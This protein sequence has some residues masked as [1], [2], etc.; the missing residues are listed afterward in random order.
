MSPRTPNLLVEW[1]PRWRAFTSALRPGLGRTP[2]LPASFTSGERLGAPRLLVL[3]EDGWR[4]FRE[5]LKPALAPSAEALETECDH[6]PLTLR[7]VALSLAVHALALMVAPVVVPWVLPPPGKLVLPEFSYPLTYYPPVEPPEQRAAVG[8]PIPEQEL[9]REMARRKRQR[10]RKPDET[11]PKNDEPKRVQ[12]A[13]QELQEQRLV[14]L[15]QSPDLPQME[16]A[17]GAQEGRSGRSG[18]REAFHPTQTIR[19]ARGPRMVE[20]VVDAPNLNLPRSDQAVANLVA[21]AAAPPPPPPVEA[22]SLGRRLLLPAELAAEVISPTAQNVGRKLASLPAAGG[23]AIVPPPPE[24]APAKAAVADPRLIVPEPTVVEPTA[25]NVGREARR[26]ALGS[27]GQIEAELT[28]GFEDGSLSGARTTGEADNGSPGGRPDGVRAAA[29][30]TGTDPN[31]APNGN[32][33]ASGLV[34]ST[35]PGDTVGVPGG[36]AGSLAMSPAG[37]GSTGLGGSGGGSGIGAGTGPGSGTHGG[38][39]GGGAS[40][41]G[42]GSDPNARGGIS[43]SPGPGGS[44]RGPSH[45]GLAGV[46][47]RGGVVNLPSFATGIAPTPPGKAP[48]QAGRRA[49]D[50]TVIATTRSGG[51]LNAY[52]VLKGPRVYTIYI[53]TRLG[54]GVMQFSERP[55]DIR[56]FQADLT[57]PEPL[58]TDFPPGTQMSR[59]VVSCVMDRSGLLTNFRILDSTTADLAYKMI[60]ALKEWRFRPVLRGEETIEVDAILGF[61]VG[62]K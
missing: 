26:L 54:T 17:G 16:D 27:A 46:T 60:A 34:I 49:P 25:A 21:V 37:S 43:P 35:R 31:G 12:E 2:Q 55:T 32:A 8:Q 38:G 48:A 4:G 53:Q 33:D 24:V 20:R 1:E 36:E 57:A 7:G 52:G 13:R 56:G 39:P 5:R 47:I 6:S 50:L 42:F 30:G 15:Q 9:A 23:P 22:A 19:V 29:Q 11:K 14:Q 41:T 40:G 59:L 3:W 58:R 10:E 44:G 28:P 45:T 61:A 62:T 18:G 51:A